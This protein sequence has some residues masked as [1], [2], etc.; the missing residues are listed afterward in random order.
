[1]EKSA[2]ASV[3]PVLVDGPEVFCVAELK[4]NAKRL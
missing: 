4:A 1:M 2:S 3:F